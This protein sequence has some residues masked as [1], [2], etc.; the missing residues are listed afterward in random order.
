MFWRRCP[1]FHHLCTHAARG[2]FWFWDVGVENGF[3][4]TFIGLDETAM[5][6]NGSQPIGKEPTVRFRSV[7]FFSFSSQLLKKGWSLPGKSF[8]FGRLASTSGLSSSSASAPSWYL[9]WLFWFQHIVYKIKY[10]FRQFSVCYGLS[11]NQQSTLLFRFFDNC[12]D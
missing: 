11:K 12:P 7:R 6:F 5:V 9:F 1:S 10:I 2:Q 4:V 3:G 8:N